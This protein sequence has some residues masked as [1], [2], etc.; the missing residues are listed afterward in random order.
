MLRIL[1]KV[2]KSITV[3]FYAFDLRLTPKLLLCFNFSSWDKTTK[4][5]LKVEQLSI[6]HQSQTLTIAL[7]HF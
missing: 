2:A 7:R 5:Y 6:K 4:L 1:A 3:G